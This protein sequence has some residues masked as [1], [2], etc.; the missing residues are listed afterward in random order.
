[1]TK[2]EKE[3]YASISFAKNLAKLCVYMTDNNAGFYEHL[4]FLSREEQSR[5]LREIIYFRCAKVLL[6]LR[7]RN[8]YKL[9][10]LKISFI[11]DV[12]DELHLPNVGVLEYR[13]NS[14]LRAN[15]P[16]EYTSERLQKNAQI[17]KEMETKMLFNFPLYADS[18]EEFDSTTDKM[19]EYFL[20]DPEKQR[21]MRESDKGFQEYLKRREQNRIGCFVIIAIVALIIYFIAS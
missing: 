17:S 5:L 16:N 12:K 1:M 6:K 9:D 18:L 13:I 8:N 4:S 20:A 11:S 21:Q 7:E 10:M 3:F 14:Y 2:E 19:I 15:A